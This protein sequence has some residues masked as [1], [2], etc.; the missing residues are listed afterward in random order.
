[1]NKARLI[2]RL[3]LENIYHVPIKVKRIRKGLFVLVLGYLEVGSGK[4]NL[5]WIGCCHEIGVIL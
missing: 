5:L 2:D 1:M 3:Y 4:Q